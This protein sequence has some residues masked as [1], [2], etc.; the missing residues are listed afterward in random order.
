TYCQGDCSC[1]KYELI[2]W[3]KE[4]PDLMERYLRYLHY[5]YLQEDILQRQVK[6]KM[7]EDLEETDFST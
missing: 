5:C 6:K 2:C 4:N 7:W 3:L 1:K